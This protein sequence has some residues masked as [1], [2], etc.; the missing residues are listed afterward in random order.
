ME[1]GWQDSCVLAV[2]IKREFRSFWWKRLTASAAQARTVLSP[3]VATVTA[4]DEHHCLVEAGAD[5]V[6]A[7]AWYLAQAALRLDVELVVLEPPEL[8]ETLVRQ[9]ERLRAFGL[10]SR[11]SSAAR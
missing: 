10:S 5:R 11:A 3:M 2:F 9:G 6:E 1:L 8:A 7:L 4:I